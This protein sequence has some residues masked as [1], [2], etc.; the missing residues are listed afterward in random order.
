MTKSK[1]E[2]QWEI[3]K[4]KLVLLAV[5]S[6]PNQDELINE[7]NR[8]CGEHLKNYNEVVIFFFR[9][10]E[11]V[12]KFTELLLGKSKSEE[13]ALNESQCFAKFICSTLTFEEINEDIEF[14]KY[15]SPISIT[16]TIG[17]KDYKI[18]RFIGTQDSN[19]LIQRQ[20]KN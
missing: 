3:D 2:N 11:H 14:E 17:I 7:C 10:V 20:L 5:F 12:D 9:S 1:V 13:A 16:K 8:M 19:T 4:I 6:S 18:K 15:L